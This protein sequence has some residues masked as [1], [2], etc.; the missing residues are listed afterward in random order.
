[1]SAER[2]HIFANFGRTLLLNPGC[3]TVENTQGWLCANP[4]YHIFQ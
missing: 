2:L 3:K 4:T 1:M